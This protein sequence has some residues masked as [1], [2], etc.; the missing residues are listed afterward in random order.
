MSQA[1]RI[2]EY[3]N[4]AFIEPAR[5]AG[6]ADVAIE[7]GDVHKDLKLQN[8]MPAVCSALDAEKFQADYGVMLIH[9]SGPRQGSTVKWIFS[10]RQ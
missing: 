5:N 3:A 2:R 8:R 6:I 4:K 9:R 10:L 1:D 7:A